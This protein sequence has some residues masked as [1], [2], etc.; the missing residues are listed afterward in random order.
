MQYQP[1]F[2]L[3]AYLL[4]VDCPVDVQLLDESGAAIASFKAHTVE[5]CDTD[6]AEAVGYGESDML[7]LPY[8]KSYTLRV[9]GTDEGTM[10]TRI[11][12]LDTAKERIG[13]HS[14]IGLPVTTDES[15]TLSLYTD[16]AAVPT[17]QVFRLPDG[18]PVLPGAGS[19]VMLPSDT[20]RL[21]DNAFAGCASLEGLL[22]CP[23]G[24]EAI[25]ANAFKDCAALTGV[26]LPDTV[27][28]IA[29]TAFAGC[30]PVIYCPKSATAV[31]SYAQAHGLTVVEVQ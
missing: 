17:Q 18:T 25:G 13:A 27:T 5:S 1:L 6:A 23:A 16:A 22:Y 14:Y 20:K 9:T 15:M 31:I 10:D 12:N 24:M 2:K 26:W 7:M 11:Y 28:T 8:G 4:V 30:S 29:D 19:R 21:A 3:G